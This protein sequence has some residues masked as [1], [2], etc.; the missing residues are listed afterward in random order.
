MMMMMYH[1]DDE[2]QKQWQWYRELNTNCT[3]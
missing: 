1:D 3:I 2:W